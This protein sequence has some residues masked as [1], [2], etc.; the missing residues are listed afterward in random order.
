MDVHYLCHICGS[1][2][3]LNY[4]ARCR[5]DT[6]PAHGYCPECEKAYPTGKL[7]VHQDWFDPAT[8]GKRE[9]SGE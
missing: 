2:I 3:T 5:P 9:A 6:I 1:E 8:R 4:P 7:R